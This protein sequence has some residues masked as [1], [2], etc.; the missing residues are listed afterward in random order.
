MNRATTTIDLGRGYRAIV[1]SDTFE[2]LRLGDYRWRVLI[3]RG[4][5]YIYGQASVCGESFYLHRV[6]A[7]AAKGQHVDHIDHDG[8]NNRDD[9]LRL[10]TPG[11][12]RANSRKRHCVSGYKGVTWSQSG[13]NWVA[14]ITKDGVR[15]YLGVFHDKRR[16]ALAHDRAA[17]ALNGEFAGLNFPDRP[18]RAVMPTGGFRLKPS[19]PYVPKSRRTT[20]YQAVFPE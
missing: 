14:T 5:K 13:H 10:C 8:L 6:V 12:N 11:E 2:R 15:Y 7:G 18:T 1:Y 17:L 16:A 3:G 9:N 20:Y 4:G 19:K